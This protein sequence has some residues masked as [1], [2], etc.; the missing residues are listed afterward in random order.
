MFEQK[1]AEERVKLEKKTQMMELWREKKE[2]AE[3]KLFNFNIDHLDVV[4]K[5]NSR[6]EDLEREYKQQKA[7]LLEKQDKIDD[8]KEKMAGRDSKLIEQK[9]NLLKEVQ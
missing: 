5:L 9:K 2:Q 1:L 4:Q 3:K 7:L 6:I 8:L